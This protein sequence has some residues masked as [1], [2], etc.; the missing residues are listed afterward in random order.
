MRSSH[1]RGVCAVLIA[2]ASAACGSGAS[3]APSSPAPKVT[4]SVVASAS[5]HGSGGPSEST[6]A[7]ASAASMAPQILPIDL[8]S[9]HWTKIADVGVS[10]AWLPSAPQVA[11]GA[12]GYAMLAGGPDG[13]ITNVRF[14]SD[15]RRWTTVDLARRVT[16]CPGYGP[17][18]TE[19]VSDAFAGA[20]ATNGHSFVVVG[21]EQPHDATSCADI[22]RSVRPVAWYSPDG[23]T[24]HRSAP[25]EVGGNNLRATAVW[26][27]PTGWQA[28]GIN[29]VWESND[30]LSWRELSEPSDV[31]PADV[32]V[33]T[34]SDGSVVRFD[35]T[36]NGLSVARDGQK[37][38]PIADAGRC[39]PG[40]LQIL[41]PV[42][43]GLAAWVVRGYKR[44]CTS[45]DLVAWSGATM[46]A[47]P[48]ALAQTSY[49]AIVIGDTCFGEGV[50]CAPDPTIAITT[51]GVTWSPLPLPA[52]DVGTAVMDGPA[53]VLMVGGKKIWRLDPASE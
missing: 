45:R 36:A 49:G 27:T 28:A 20:I 53:G 4:A 41:G 40:A 43:P 26:A 47:A 9:A 33:G 22:R 8:A 15:G 6:S 24:W 23:Q 52:K 51:D 30:G 29:T 13:N 19:Q 46:K 34:S 2:A 14:S 38:S 17:A 44:V 25:F 31:F 3:S 32:V 18:G 7:S 1:L 12:V 42:R 50:T 10:P 48:S 21:E 39:D 5:A 16:N 37:W 35:T 11:S